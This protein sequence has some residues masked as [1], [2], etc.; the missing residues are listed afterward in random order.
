VV[1]QKMNAKIF[2][3][4][5]NVKCA[6]LLYLRTLLLVLNVA[7]LR[8]KWAGGEHIDFLF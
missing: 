7:M 3:E 8:K 4:M 2:D 5:C 1:A 6:I